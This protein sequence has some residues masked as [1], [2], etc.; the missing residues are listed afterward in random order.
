MSRLDLPE[1]IEIQRGERYR[2][3]VIHAPAIAGK[4]ETARALAQVVPDA[5]YLDL[6]DEWAKRP[7]S[8]QQIDRFG[9]PELERYL[10]QVEAEGQV[11]IVDHLDLVLNTWTR[12]QRQAFAQWV[13][14]GLDGFTDT[15]R[16]FVFFVQ[17]DAAIAEYPMRRLNGWGRTRIFRLDEFNAL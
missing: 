16:V 3:V 1:L 10:L 9:V 11:I 15:N 8:V 5:R 2:A 13:D 14:D 7:D 4:T 6:L 17:T 12:T